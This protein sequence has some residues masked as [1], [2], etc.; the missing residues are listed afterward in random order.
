[1]KRLVLTLGL[2]LVM[3]SSL[4]AKDRYVCKDK[5]W[6]EY[7]NGGKIEFRVTNREYNADEKSKFICQYIDNVYAETRCSY[8]VVSFTD[9]NGKSYHRENEVLIKVQELQ[10]A[11]IGTLTSYL[12]NLRQEL[13]D[14]GECKIIDFD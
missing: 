9:I 8:D 1:M 14:K 13:I 12:T 5:S 4:Y 11:M 3:G 6:E 10:T 7:M 2:G